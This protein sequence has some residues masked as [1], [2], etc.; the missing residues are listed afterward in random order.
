MPV[1]VTDSTAITHTDNVREKDTTIIERTTVIREADSSLLAELAAMGYKVDGYNNVL[2]VLQRELQ[3]KIRELE[4]HKADTV[5]QYK[6][7]PTPYPVEKEVEK[8][9]TKWQQFRM[10]LGT[11]A[12]IAAAV[13]L[14]FLCFRLWQKI[15]K[16]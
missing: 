8:P 9:L 10:S 14:L 5:I 3:Q 7:V 15:K 4:S 6:E 1:Y 13:C 11:I 16:N 12:I 2:C